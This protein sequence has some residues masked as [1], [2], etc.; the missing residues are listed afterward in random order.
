MLVFSGEVEVPVLHKPVPDRGPS[1]Q[2]NIHHKLHSPTSI[3]PNIHPPYT[4]GLSSASLMDQTSTSGTEADDPFV[5]NIAIKLSRALNLINP[6]DLLAKRVI[7]IAKT[8]SEPAF[9]KGARL[10]CVEYVVQQSS[11]S[12]L[13]PCGSYSSGQVFRQVPGHILE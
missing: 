4:T 12:S 8:N 1:L 2:R 3:S 7:D 13:D 6:N 11:P 9:L 10:E 5:H